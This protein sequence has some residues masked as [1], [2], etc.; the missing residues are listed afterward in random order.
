[1]WETAPSGV[2]YFFF[3]KEVITHSNIWIRERLQVWSISQA[4]EST[5][6]CATSCCP[7]LYFFAT[8]MTNKAQIFP[9]L[10]FYVYLFLCLDTGLWQLPN[11]SRAFNKKLFLIRSG[12]SADDS[13]VNWFVRLPWF[14]VLISPYP[15][16][17]PKAKTALNHQNMDW[18]CL[19]RI[20]KLFNVFVVI[21]FHFATFFS[22]RE[23]WLRLAQALQEFLF[24]NWQQ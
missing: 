9:D 12:P 23:G 10:L 19:T 17:L 21:F 13:C 4:S 7:F 8:S 18:L 22:L 2:T 16:C 5:Q 24:L 11:M 20:I 1:M 6:I 14:I 3:E 15:I